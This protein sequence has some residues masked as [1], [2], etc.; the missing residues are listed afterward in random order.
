MNTCVYQ[1]E[2]VKLPKIS[3]ILKIF[4]QIAKMLCQKMH[5]LIVSV[6]FLKVIKL[7]LK[8]IKLAKAIEMVKNIVR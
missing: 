3:R 8:G 2:T 1:L 7:I 6:I 5:Y 4:D